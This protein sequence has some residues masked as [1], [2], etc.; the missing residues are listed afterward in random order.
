MS[1]VPYSRRHLCFGWWSVLVFLTLGGVLEALHGFKVGWYLDVSNEA[2]RL[3]WTLA[4][5]HGVLLGLV[6][7]GFGLTVRLLPVAEASWKRW[8]SSCLIG[9]SVLL[10][11]GFF[12]GGLVTHGGDPGLAILL[13]PPGALLLLIAIVLI[14][15]ATGSI[16]ESS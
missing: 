11:G 4:H 12:L 10:P 6:H 1:H 14:A 16:D 15:R 8:A 9:A 7:V 5:A 2:R 13:A 3:M